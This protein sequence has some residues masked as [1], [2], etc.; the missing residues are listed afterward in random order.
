R[1][2]AGH[3]YKSHLVSAGWHDCKERR[4]GSE[5]CGWIRFAEISYRRAGNVGYHHAGGFSITSTSPLHKDS[6]NCS[7]DGQ[8]CM[9]LSRSG[10]AIEANALGFADSDRRRR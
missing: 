4:K 5:E 6:F 3:D 8:P 9:A 1:W 10:K 2:A 7:C